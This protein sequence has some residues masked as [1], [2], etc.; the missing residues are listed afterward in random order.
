MNPYYQEKNITIYHGDCLEIMPQLEPVDLVLTDPPYGITSN[1][2]DKFE[3]TLSAFDLLI[4]S[5]PLVCT[6]QN[7][8][9]AELICMYRKYFKWSDIWEKSQT[10]G[11]LSC[12]IMPLRKH[13]DILIFSD[14]KIPYYPQITKKPDKNI[15]PVS[16]SGP[17]SNYGSFK[18]HIQQRTIGIDEQ[19]PT[20]IFFCEN[21]QNGYHPNEKPL[22]LIDYLMKTYSN[23]N[24]LI[25]DPFMGSGT[26]LVAAKELGRKAIGIE[27]EE[28]YC[29]IA[30][31]RLRQEV[32]NWGPL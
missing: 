18:G 20:S 25:L 30:V 1:N 9:S 14:G 16:I 8:A 21:S 5:C 28:K 29:E 11:F 17:S 3:V 12:K 7:P 6:S 26:T 24:D 27:I 10:R 22:K 31:D 4:G 19:Y 32:F 2:W 13:E 15:R 23:R